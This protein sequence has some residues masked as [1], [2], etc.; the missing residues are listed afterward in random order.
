MLTAV[1]SSSGIALLLRFIMELK[2]GPFWRKNPR[3]FFIYLVY[4]FLIRSGRPRQW[5]YGCPLHY[6]RYT[7]YYMDVIDKIVPSEVSK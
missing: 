6:T 3:I 1:F 7:M 2:T 4:L 5:H